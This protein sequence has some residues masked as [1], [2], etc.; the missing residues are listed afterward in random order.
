M[1]K[2]SHFQ[3]VLSLVNQD[4]RQVTESA[5]ALFVEWYNPSPE[6]EIFQIEICHTFKSKS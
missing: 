2:R 6:E 1:T 3:F 4:Y 5:V